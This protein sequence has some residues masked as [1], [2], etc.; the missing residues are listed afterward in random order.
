[1]PEKST[2][3]RIV[4]AAHHGARASGLNRQRLVEAAVSRVHGSYRQYC[5]RLRQAAVK[6]R[7][8]D[9]AR[10]RKISAEHQSTVKTPH[11]KQQES[12]ECSVRNERCRAHIDSIRG[13]VVSAKDGAMVVKSL[14]TACCMHTDL[15]LLGWMYCDSRLYRSF[16]PYLPF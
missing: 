11:R 2:A 16:I 14:N 3:S 5:R 15:I 9:C 6:R 8:Q 10:V 4:D 1:M 13:A 12:G 7:P